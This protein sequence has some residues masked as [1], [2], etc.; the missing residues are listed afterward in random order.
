WT[1]LIYA[2]TG[3]RNDVVEY[4]LAQGAQINA[5]SPNGTSALMMAVREGKGSTVTLLIARGADVN[6]RNEN[7]ASALAWA[8]RGNEKAMAAELR[9]AGAKS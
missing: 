9:K 7:G 5:V 6:H 1:P 8:E 3:G 4:L 2:A